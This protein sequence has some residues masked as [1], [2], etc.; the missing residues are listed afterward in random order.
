MLRTLLAG[1]TAALLLVAGLVIAPAGSASESFGAIS[2]KR[3]V[4]KPKCA[5]YHYRYRIDV[6]SD[7]WAAETFL[8]G[9]RGGGVASGALLSGPNAKVG[10]SSWRLCRASIISGRYTI[11]MKV[12]YKVGY[13]KFESFVKPSHLRLVRRR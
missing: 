1:T 13:D 4:L 3:Q 7:N 5:S 10:R 6:P 8:V 12:T 9:P 11:R 2:A